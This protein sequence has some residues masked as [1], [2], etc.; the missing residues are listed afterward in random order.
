MH[1]EPSNQSNTVNK[2][3]LKTM[4]RLNRAVK[5]LNLASVMNINPRSAY[6]CPEKLALLIKEKQID[7]AFLSESW[8]RQAFTLEELLGDLLED[9]QILTN[10]QPG[11]RAGQED[12]LLS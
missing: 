3:K 7:A 12:G 5:A 11:S 6:N 4:Q 8:E 10:P 9:Y 1:R 2:S